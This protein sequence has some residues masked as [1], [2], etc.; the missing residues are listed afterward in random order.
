MNKE[1]ENDACYLLTEFPEQGLEAPSVESPPLAKKIQ[2]HSF[3]YPAGFSLR[4]GQEMLSQ[5]PV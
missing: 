1:L 4:P 3:G 5:D 2:D